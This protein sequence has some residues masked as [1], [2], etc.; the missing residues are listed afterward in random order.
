[1]LIDWKE[2]LHCAVAVRIGATQ[3]HRKDW[4]AEASKLIVLS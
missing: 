4:V 1:M 2:G 3:I